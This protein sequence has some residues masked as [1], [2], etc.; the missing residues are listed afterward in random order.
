MS[1]PNFGLI[2][3][4]IFISYFFIFLL[5]SLYYYLLY[6]LFSSSSFLTS[7][8]LELFFVSLISYSILFIISSVIVYLKEHHCSNFTPP[9]YNYSFLFL[10]PLFL[11]LLVIYFKHHFSNHFYLLS[12]I[13]SIFAI[14][15]YI[16]TTYILNQHQISS[17]LNLS[18]FIPIVIYI[19][20]RISLLAGNINSMRISIFFMSLFITL[21]GMSSFYLSF[22]INNISNDNTICH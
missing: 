21:L 10:A 8:P 12:S 22:I 4:F 1:F 7:I 11:F 9:W 19:L 20:I 16:Q 13:L 3:I 14:L 17:S 18:M 6:F 15:S 5:S 2:V